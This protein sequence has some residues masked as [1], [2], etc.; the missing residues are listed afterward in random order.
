MTSLTYLETKELIAAASGQI[1]LPGYTGGTTDAAYLKS[2]L[3]PLMTS[4]YA[5]D[6]SVFETS[7]MASTTLIRDF[8]NR[9]LRFHESTVARDSLDALGETIAPSFKDVAS[10]LRYPATGQCGEHN[11][12]LYQIYKAFGFDAA[13]VGSVNGVGEFTIGHVQALVK[14]SEVDGWIA[15]DSYENYLFTS[16][17][18]QVLS[19]EDARVLAATDIQDLKFDALDSYLE[20]SATG[21]VRP[22]TPENQAIIL[23]AVFTL[24]YNVEY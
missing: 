17:D 5:V 20:Y 12:Q 6:A 7:T 14:V 10:L 4:Y 8:L 22:V 21:I 1:T 18:G 9:A 2:Y 13:W 23:D 11:W 3:V 16:A 24:Q 15:Q 19:Y